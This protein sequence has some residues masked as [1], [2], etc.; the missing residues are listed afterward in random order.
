MAALL[1]LGPAAPGSAGAATQ[2][3]SDSLFVRELGA[4]R[5]T[6]IV[7][8]GGPGFGHPIP[9][10]R[11][12]PFG[13]GPERGPEVDPRIRIRSGCRLQLMRG[14]LGGVP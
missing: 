5:S 13:C 11:V 4:G 8:H 10:P 6:V 3:S 9:S 12:G 1:L 14:P 2:G 7:L